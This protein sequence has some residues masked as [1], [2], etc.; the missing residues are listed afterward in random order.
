MGSNALVT[1]LPSM[2]AA[3]RGAAGR[4]ELRDVE[5]YAETDYLLDLVRGEHDAAAVER[6]SDRVAALTGLDPALVRRRAGKVDIGAFTRDREPG[7]V[8]SPYDATISATDPFPA[9]ANDNSPVT[10][11]KP[12]PR[13][14]SGWV[15]K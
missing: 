8:A 4:A 7:R 13:S 3:A 9:A 5:N 6:I 11:A 15:A 1:R 12:R 2:A 10:A 14:G